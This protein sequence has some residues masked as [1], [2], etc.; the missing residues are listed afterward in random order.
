MAILRDLRNSSK[1]KEQSLALE[2]DLQND[3]PLHARIPYTQPQCGNAMRLDPPMLTRG[4]LSG[5]IYVVTH[6][7][8]EPHPTIPGRTM[9][10]A[11]VK[12]DVTD[13]FQALMDEAI[14][15]AKVRETL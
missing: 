8:I 11:S 12:Y 2:M 7:K 4:P 13:Q 14:I 6:G 15:V 3:I 9:V 5:A 1:R 10:I